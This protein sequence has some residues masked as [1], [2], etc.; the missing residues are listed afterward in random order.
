MYLKVINF[1]PTIVTGGAGFIGSHLTEKLISMG[2]IVTV[3]DNLSSGNIQNLI[4]YKDN[5]L[6]NLIETNVN[7][8]QINF[9]NIKTVFH[10]AAYPEVSTGFENPS[11]AYRE[12]VENTFKFLESIRKSNVKNLVFASSSVVYGEP[13]TIPTP[14]SYGPLLPIS[15]YGGSKLACEGL[16][17]S[18]CN[19][20]GIRCSIVRFA[21]V[22][23]SRSNHGII[24]DFIQ[25]LLKNNQSLEILGDG[26]QSK[27]YIHV[28]DCINGILMSLDESGKSIDVDNI[29]N[30]DK[31]DVMTIA[32]IVCNT[33]SLENVKFLTV[34]GTSD[35]RGW[36]G[37]VKH[38]LLDTTKLKNLGW[39]PKLSSLEAIQLSSKEIL[40]AIQNNSLD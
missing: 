9:D 35:G 3:I 36:V 19:N 13:K 22:I 21:N 29:G 4:R 17:S 30:D 31:V 28:N 39:T 27:S 38:M 15:S 1:G 24:W 5:K 11:L 34:G 14:E 23:G 2:E 26:T 10:L 7:N 40:Q 12:N 33:L 20:Y 16:I 18:Y 37:D 8:E 25:K 32:K 6:F